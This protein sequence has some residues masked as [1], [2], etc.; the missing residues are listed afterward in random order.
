MSENTF[1]RA[2]AIA[3]ALSVAMPVTAADSWEPKTEQSMVELERAFWYCDF[4][5]TTE[6]VQA[7]PVAACRFA[8][9]QLKK[10]KFA[11]NFEEFLSW[12]RANKPT[13]HLKLHEERRNDA[14]L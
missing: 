11:G 7:T 2:A 1:A 14:L 3:I 5:A 12:W 13:E 8:T 6:G 4:I 9:E 10:R